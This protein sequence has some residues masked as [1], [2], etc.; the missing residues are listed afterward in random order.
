L[1]AT[2][3]FPETCAYD[4]QLYAHKR[5]ITGCDHS[6]WSQYNLSEQS[7]TIVNPCPL[8][9]IAAAVAAP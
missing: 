2:E 4:L 5:T 9:P 3:A 7:F 8:L 6:F 1:P